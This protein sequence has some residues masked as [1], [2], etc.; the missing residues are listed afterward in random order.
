[1]N[2]SKVH[3]SF[4]VFFENKSVTR[5]TSKKVS[6]SLFILC[7]LAGKTFTI[8]QIFFAR[9]GLNE[10]KLLFVMFTPKDWLESLLHS[11][12]RRD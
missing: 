9:G 6:Y 10:V 5:K 11:L 12:G 7:S 8:V 1:M 4:I 3:S 2:P